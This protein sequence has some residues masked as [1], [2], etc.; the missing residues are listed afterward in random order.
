MTDLSIIII[1]KNRTRFPVTH[2]GKEVVLKLFENNLDKLLE[3]HQPESET[4]ELVLCDF[5]S[6]DVNMADFLKQ[7]FE[8]AQSSFTYQLHTIPDKKFCKG[9][10]LNIASKL[11]K[12]ENLFYLDADMLI[13]SRDIFTQAYNHL[14]AS[15]VYFPICMNYENP[16]QTVT[17]ARPSG[18]GNVFI[19]KKNLTLKPWPE[20]NK[21]GNEDTHFY[22][23]FK[24]KKLAVRSNVATF[25]HQ[26]HPNTFNFKN[27]Y[28]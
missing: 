1:I 9:K 11:A 15:R 12:Y 27:R 5:N 16:E 10:G 26:W 3:L 21:W 17:K 23:F 18:T 6:T 14:T 2:N 19:S 24:T 22:Q 8:A 28:Y 13:T 7:K 20:Y 4:W 25:F